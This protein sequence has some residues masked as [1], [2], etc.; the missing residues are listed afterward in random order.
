MG[1]RL[2][3]PATPPIDSIALKMKNSP[4]YL[5]IPIAPVSSDMLLGTPSFT[6]APPRPPTP[7]MATMNLDKHQELDHP[8]PI[9]WIHSNLGMN[10]AEHVYARKRRKTTLTEQ[11]TLEA[12][13]L[14]NPKPSSIERHRIANEL[15][16]PSKTVQ[17]WFQ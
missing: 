12:N 5:D 7:L 8:V 10:V 1:Y 4:T 11:E 16:I 13:F 17:I 3:A 6:N 9:N 14:I 15:K 2:L